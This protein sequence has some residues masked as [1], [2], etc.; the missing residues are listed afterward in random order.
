MTRNQPNWLQDLLEESRR[1]DQKSLAG[2]SNGVGRCESCSGV[3]ATV[4][5][6]G[7]DRPEIRLPL[8]SVSAFA[9]DPPRFGIEGGSKPNQLFPSLTGRGAEQRQVF[10]SPKIT[11]ICGGCGARLMS[12]GGGMA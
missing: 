4:V 10:S 12:F 8:A 3:A 1:C 6:G 7:D 9:G 11:I 5:L 2:L